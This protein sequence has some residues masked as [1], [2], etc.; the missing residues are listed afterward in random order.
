MV[1]R[2]RRPLVLP[3]TLEVDYA[4][5]TKDRIRIPVEAWLAKGTARTRS[6]AIS[7]WRA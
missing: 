5:G 2:N 6:T 1:V 4:D 7:R 3:A